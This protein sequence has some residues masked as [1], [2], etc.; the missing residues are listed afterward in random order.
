MLILL[1]CFWFVFIIGFWFLVVMGDVNSFFYIF[2]V[3]FIF[4]Y[5]IFDFLWC[6]YM[7]IEGIDMLLYYMVFICFLVY[8]FF[9]GYL[10]FEFVVVVL[11]IEIFN[12]FL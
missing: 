3:I 5:F 2:I 11:G 1:L 12:S 8:I 10:G 9:D 6:F 4:G 7:G